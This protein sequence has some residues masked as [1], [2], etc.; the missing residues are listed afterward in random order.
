MMYDADDAYL[1][2]IAI[3]TGI[4]SIALVPPLPD[5]LDVL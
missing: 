4:S 3:W 1:R 2:Q 5:R